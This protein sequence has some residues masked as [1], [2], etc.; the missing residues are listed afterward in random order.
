MIASYTLG[1]LGTFPPSLSPSSATSGV[2]AV[3]LLVSIFLLF[4]VLLLLMLLLLGVDVVLAPVVVVGTSRP[5]LLLGPQLAS[6][7]GKNFLG[8]GA[9]KPF[10]LFFGFRSPSSCVTAEPDTEAVDLWEGCG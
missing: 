3:L 4:L 5:A 2:D 6:G 1:F 10:L 7:L 9:L 8:L